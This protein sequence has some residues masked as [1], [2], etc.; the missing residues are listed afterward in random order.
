VR[1]RLRRPNVR[2][3]APALPNGLTLGNLFFG[4]FAIIAASRGQFDRAVLYIVLGGVCDAFDGRVARAT[5]TGGRFGEELDSLVDAI[6]FGLAPAMI[7]YFSVLS[8][9]RLGPYAVFLF[10]AC[11]VLR[12]AR[13]NVT[14]AGAS[15]S[16][17][18]GLPSPAAGGTLAT[19]YWFSQTSL[20]QQTAIVG[21]P[22]Q[23]IMIW[24]MIILAFLMVSNVPYPAWPKVGL[25]SMRA[26]LG[27]VLVLAIVLGVAYFQRSFFFP[28]GV[29][30]VAYGLV[31]AVLL[32]MWE[33][34][35]GGD[36]YGMVRPRPEI[37][38]LAAGGAGVQAS[39]PLLDEAGD[40]ELA[41]EVDAA[42]PVAS[43]DGVPGRR[44]RRRRK[45]RGGSIPPSH[46]P[47]DGPNE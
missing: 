21:L 45:G 13:F 39:Y 42:A 24:L 5:G 26:A 8:Q 1:D 11:A 35:P 46:R 31:R 34:R 27:L 38:G 2:R 33:R 40:D 17:F 41:D 18:M 23:E 16:Y 10:A 30:Y 4:I 22:W 43:L 15:K 20:Y 19:Y 32:G 14:Q 7:V 36:V 37:A 29:A 28:F 47:V 12:L 3:A 9:D 25:R 44:R 6:S